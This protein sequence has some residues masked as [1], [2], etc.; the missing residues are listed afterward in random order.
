M[1]KSEIC[2]MGSYHTSTISN[3]IITILIANNLFLTPTT[4][5]FN[6]SPKIF[7]FSNQKTT[8][9]QNMSIDTYLDD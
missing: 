1:K 5:F 4:F 8:K 7:N 3:Y 9:T 6:F 2:M